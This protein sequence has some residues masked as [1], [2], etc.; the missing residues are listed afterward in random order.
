MDDCGCAQ[1]IAGTREWQ[2]CEGVSGLPRFRENLFRVRNG[3]EPLPDYV[4]EP[5]AMPSTGVSVR[6]VATASG[7]Q[8]SG[9]CQSCQ[10][11]DATAT[12]NGRGPGSQLIDIFKSAGFQ[13]CES[14][15]ALAAQMDVWGSQLCT[16]KMDAIV[17]DILPRALEW[18]REKVGWWAKLM[19]EAVTAAAIKVMVSRAIDLAAK[20]EPARITLHQAPR[21][22]SDIVQN[23]SPRNDGQGPPIEMVPLDNATR[24][25]TFHIW[26]VKDFGAWQ[27]NCDRLI[28]NANL[29]NGR[30]IV[31]IV[32]DHQSDSAEMVKAY[33]SRFTDEFIV[34]PNN[35]NLR[36]V[37]TWLPM[38]KMLESYQSENDVTFSSHAK[39]VR[40]KI[41]ADNEGS[42]V[43]R[44]TAAMWELCTRW[45]VV[46]PLLESSA[47]VG[48]F[49]RFGPHSHKDGFGPW[50]F[51]GS[52]FWWRNRDA[53]RRNWSYTPQ[54][55]FGT[56][57]WPG[58]MFADHE[59]AVIACDRVEDLYKMPYWTEHIEPQLAAWR[60]E[61]VEN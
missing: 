20:A 16:A 22:T 21:V 4:V 27:W 6:V 26:P 61:H 58:I 24:H 46:R 43:Y 37:T 49:R 9:N 39:C 1:F 57:A 18:E 52:F 60:A 3:L 36:E 56:E 48:A 59:A 50:H 47:T 25:L 5:F 34:V 15:Y 33:L 8:R 23:Q 45:D 42:T 40:H 19:P 2:I 7:I 54:R 14:C 13:A 55:F 12:L 11:T 51:S 35:P 31:S 38:L 53:Y 29:F 41:N 30:R 32:V 28:A 17:A 10:K 44:W